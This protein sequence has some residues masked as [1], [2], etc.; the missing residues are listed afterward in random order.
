MTMG[1]EPMI[2]TLPG[3]V[4]LVV[5]E[6]IAHDQHRVAIPPLEAMV[7]GA[8]PAHED[9]GLPFGHPFH[10]LL[11]LI[12][13]TAGD[14]DLLYGLHHYHPLPAA[15]GA[16]LTPAP[17]LPHQ[18]PYPQSHGDQGPPVGEGAPLLSS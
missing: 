16:S 4:T 6:V 10:Y 15:S 3:L 5:G 13:A 12:P 1:P 18:Q 8:P 17:E 2:R 7:Q 9:E 11:H 14:D